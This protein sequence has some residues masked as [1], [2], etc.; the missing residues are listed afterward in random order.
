MLESFSHIDLV[1]LLL[2]FGLYAA[3]VLLMGSLLL[4]LTLKPTGLIAAALKRQLWIGVFVLIA[5]CLSS[6]V[7]LL[8]DWESG[9]TMLLEIPVGQAV[10]LRFLAVAVVIGLLLLRR[11]RF[12]AIVSLFIAVSFG[13]EGHSQSLE[14]CRLNSS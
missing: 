5:V 8:I 2:R 4:Q 13:L 7:K 10:L 1:S 11:V 6:A 14:L 12:A 9:P 3:T